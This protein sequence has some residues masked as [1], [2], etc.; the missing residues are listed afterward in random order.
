[1]AKPKKTSIGAE[2]RYEV[3]KIRGKDGKIR[4]SRGNADA[5]AKALLLHIAN[6]GELAQVVHAN[7]LDD[8]MKPHAKKAPGLARMILG[9][10]LRALVRNGTP[11]KVGKVTVEKL[12][13]K[14]ELPK[15]EK[16]VAKKVNSKGR[17]RKAK[18]EV[19][20]AA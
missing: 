11:V 3:L 8:R 4:T 12:T 10:M 14:V 2:Y 5:V 1:M 6:G 15:V 7:K 20:A 19:A 9:V 17:P 13:Q 18:A 16:A